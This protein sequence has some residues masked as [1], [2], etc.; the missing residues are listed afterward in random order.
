MDSCASLLGSMIANI[1]DGLLRLAINASSP[2]THLSAR[3]RSIAHLRVALGTAR[4]ALRLGC[5][6]FSRNY[7][8]P[9]QTYFISRNASMP[10]REP[11]RPIPDSFTPPKGATSVEMMPVLTPTIPYSS[12]SLT[13]WMRPVSR[14]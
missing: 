2:A 7:R 3:P 4:T 6:G 11:S 9:W 5:A 1:T 13:R 12:A 8:P 14:A 10:C